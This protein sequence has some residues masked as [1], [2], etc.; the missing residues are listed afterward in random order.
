MNEDD[1]AH[2]DARWEALPRV[3]DYKVHVALFAKSGF[4]SSLTK[5]ATKEGIFL[6]LGATLEQE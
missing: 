4:T 6:Y 2:L 3:K 1:L 5:R